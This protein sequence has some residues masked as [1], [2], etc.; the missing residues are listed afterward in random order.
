MANALQK[1]ENANAMKSFFL[2]NMSHEI[3]SP[4]NAVLGFNDLLREE[5]KDVV[6]EEQSRFFDHVKESGNRLLHTVQ[7]ILDTSQVEAGTYTVH[8]EAADLS[9]IIKSVV[10]SVNIL[11]EEA[12]L[13][14]EYKSKAENTIIIIDIYSITRV[15]RNLINNAI[16]FT[17]KGYIKV[18]LFETDENLILTIKDTGIGVS[19]E[20]KNRIFEVFTQGSEGFS[21]KYEGVGLGLFLVKRYLDLNNVDMVFESEKDV[22]TTVTLTFVKNL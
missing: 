13:I 7:E 14:L 10:E 6:N 4:L 2:A 21:K 19:E 20:D 12:D 3:R 17:E 18:G 16:K 5:L 22:G 15:L 8:P 11:A 9:S 1:A